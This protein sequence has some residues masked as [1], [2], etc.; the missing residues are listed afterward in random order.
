MSYANNRIRRLPVFFLL[1]TA[2]SLAGTLEVTM[3]QGLLMVKNE[4]CK[5]PACIKSVYLSSIT[6]GE[7]HLSQPLAP[8]DFF[9]QPAWQARGESILKPAL[10]SL[11]E[12]LRY[13]LILKTG[14]RSGDFAPLV[15]LV[16]GSH[17]IDNW[18]VVIP[19]L[20]TFTENQRP[21][22]VALV[23]RP[24]LAQEIKVLSQHILCLNPAEGE[25]MTNFF[26][27]VA[28][29]IRGICEDCERGATT[30]GLPAL[31]YGVVASS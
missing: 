25:C 30:I 26:L 13:D 15:F 1:D 16:L 31:P 28:Q 12:A 29:A 24:A 4:L 6:F 17:P 8:L 11:A 10:L 23:T 5:Y 18:Q 22:I 2:E 27:W 9:I 14:E 19:L 7:T 3:Q 21:L 20:Q